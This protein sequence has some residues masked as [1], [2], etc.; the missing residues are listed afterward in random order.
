MSILLQLGQQIRA[1]RK[2]AN[3]T[4]A[5]LAEASGLSDNYIALLERGKRSPS[6][7]ALDKIAGAMKVP[8]N[9]LFLFSKER[10]DI[11]HK[12]LLKKLTKSAENKNSDELSFLLDIINLLKVY[13]TRHK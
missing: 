1:I 2:D 12:D 3:K 4:Q 13:E 5:D 8:V 10:T 9:R 11:S 6:I 7:E